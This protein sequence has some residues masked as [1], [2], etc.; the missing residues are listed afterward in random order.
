M[1]KAFKNYLNQVKLIVRRIIMKCSA[2][3]HNQF[4]KLTEN[5]FTTKVSWEVEVIVQKI[6]PDAFMCEQWHLMCTYKA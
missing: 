1:I 2:C 5:P 4:Y 6:T 3:G